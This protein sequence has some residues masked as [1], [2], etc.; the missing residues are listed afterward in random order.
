MLILHAGLLAT[1][2]LDFPVVCQV[3]PLALLSSSSFSP[4]PLLNK[5]D[6]SMWEWAAVGI[7]TDCKLHNNK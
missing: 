2:S 1:V 3:L 5:D 7:P 6:G 4:N